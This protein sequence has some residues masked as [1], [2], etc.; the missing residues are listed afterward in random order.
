MSASLAIRLALFALVLVGIAEPVGFLTGSPSLRA[1]GRLS[2]ASNAPLVFNQVLG[3]EFWA[4]RYSFEFLGRDGSI[5]KLPV[6]NEVLR[7]LRG[8]HTRTAAYVV[9]VGLSVIAPPDLY[10][11]PLA[12]GLCN[13]GPLAEDLGYRGDLSVA[14]IQI[15]SGSPG[16]GRRW[17][18]DIPCDR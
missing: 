6:T 12:Y 2:S 15:E 10:R 14:T 8:P 17:T 13:H 7:R 18:V 5:V 4:S 11:P 16:D 9:P 1:F 3:I